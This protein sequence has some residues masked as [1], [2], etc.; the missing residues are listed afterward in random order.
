MATT[1]DTL[2]AAADGR[3][4]NDPA[5]L[6]RRY[7]AEW[8][9]KA[10]GLGALGIALFFLVVLFYSIISQ[11]WTAFLQT[12]IKL[13]VALNEA[14]FQDADGQITEQS[15][16]VADYTKMARDALQSTLGLES[17]TR[18]E[19][20]DLRGLLSRGVDV[21]IRSKIE[22]DR[23]VIGQTVPVW[24][25]ANG[26][27]DA[28]IK[29]SIDRN[30][31]EERRQLNN[32]QLAWIDKLIAEGRLEKQ[33]NTGLFTYGASSQPETAGLAVA[34]IGSFFMMLIVALV[35]VPIGV[36]AAAYLEEFA[37]KN[38]FTDII[39]VNINNLAAVP[40]IVFGLLGLAVFINFMGLPRSASLVGGLVLSL[41]TLPT[42]I[43]ATRAA[44]RAVPPS[45]RE[46]ALGVGA[47]KMQTLFHHVLPLAL[48]GILTGTIIGLVQ[49]LGETAPL[50]MIGLVAFVV[51]YPTTPLDPATALPVQ[52]YMWASSAERGFVERT[53]GATIVLLMFLFVMNAAAVYLRRKFERKW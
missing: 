42:V 5:M 30:T 31:P 23:S 17:P 53:M 40:S 13:D 29:G 3:K 19:K 22:S 18:P 10:Y 37:P 21:Q 35:A 47:S 43:I 51:D 15:I 50:L 24:V 2:H 7:A 28:L 34:L 6:K 16:R 32:K 46:A 11:G 25:L 36:A 8:R 9:F 44:I 12:N 45:I 48:P 4:L 14:D 27:V 49:A 41:M 20:R 52:I 39:E 33:F 26:E 1:Q 38:T